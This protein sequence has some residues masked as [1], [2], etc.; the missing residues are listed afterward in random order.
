MQKYYSA[1]SNLKD[2]IFSLVGKK[3]KGFRFNYEDSV[4][5]RIFDKLELNKNYLDEN[6]QPTGKLNIIDY[7]VRLSP[8]SY[9]L[10]NRLQPAHHLIVPDGQTSY[11]F[12]KKMELS[13]DTSL[14]NYNIMLPG[15]AGTVKANLLTK[16]LEEKML[17]PGFLPTLSEEE[18]L[19]YK[20]RHVEPINKSLLFVGDFTSV[21]S[22]SALRTCIYYNEVR[23]S[24]FRYG[25]VKFLA[26]TTPNEVLKYFGPVGSIHRRTNALMANLYSDL[27]MIACTEILKNPKASKI[28]SEMDFIPL[29]YNDAEGEICLVEFQ[30]NHNKYDIKFQDE[31]HLIIHKLFCTP[32]C[33]LRERLSV[34][35]PGAEEYFQDRV[36]DTILDKK[37]SVITDQEYV[38]FSETYYYWPFK[39][40]TGLETY[41]NQDTFFDVD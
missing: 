29:P 9:H 30:S 40:N 25:G 34:L 19:D 27:R 5:N 23:T 17:N 2:A 4:Y 26:W 18:E 6:G 12:W 28:I 38:D 3:A 24:M 21:T 11:K 7:N 14:Q 10:N 16:P 39:P 15:F 35:G 22:A 36:P 41:G 20:N 1:Q 8:F 32:G 31:L 37:I 13:N 33:A